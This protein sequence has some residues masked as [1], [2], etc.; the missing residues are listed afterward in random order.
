MKLLHIILIATLSA[1]TVTACQPQQ[2][3]RNAET[4]NALLALRSDYDAARQALRAHL[5]QLPPE[6][7]AELEVL[8][9]RADRLVET[10]TAAWVAKDP[11]ALAQAQVWVDEGL[12]IYE[13]GRALVEPHMDRLDVQTRARLRQLARDVE[14]LRAAVEQLRESDYDEYARAAMEL[15]TLALRVAALSL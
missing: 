7:I 6:V 13:T 5:D 10:V 12:D 2:I 11:L 4:A 14:R 8:E 9:E 15:V 1:L 3:T